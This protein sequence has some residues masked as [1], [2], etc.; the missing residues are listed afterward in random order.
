MYLKELSSIRNIGAMTA[1]F[2]VLLLCF[3]WIGLYNK[4]Q[5][6]RQLV[7]EDAVK[8]TANY[9]RTF[10]E[11]T[12]RTLKG[13]DQI[14]LFL[15]HQAEKDGL[16][17]DLPGF[18]KTGRFAGQPFIALNIINA[19]G[20]LVASSHAAF[21]Q[22]NTSD[23]EFF[24]A[25][26]EADSD[27]PFVG[28]PIAGRE[29][30]QMAIQLTRRINNADGSFAGVAV[31]AVDPRYFAEFYK[32][33]DL[34]EKSSIVL[35]GLDGIVWVRQ[36][37]NELSMGLDYSKGSL[38]EHVRAG[39]T[40]SLRSRNPVDGYERIGSFRVLKEY[41]LAVWVGETE[42]YVFFGLNQRMQGYIW[43][44][45]AMSV[46][47]LLFVLLL[48]YGIQRFKRA[49]AAIRS[50]QIRYKALI[51]Q[52]FEAMVLVDIE[53]QE[54]VGVNRRFTEMLGYSLPE[55]APL[56]A[57]DFVI[58]SQEELNR[59]Y[60]IILR[61]QN[62]LPV[63]SMVFRHKNGA[64]V[65][66]E[67]AG[68]VINIE[69][70]DYLL[71][72]NRDMTQ[73]HRHQQ[74]LAK[75][76]KELQAK[77]KLLE[78]TN[79]LLLKSQRALLHQASH[80]SLT[81]LLNSRAA[82]GLLSKEL[83]RSQR[84]GEGL[85]VGMCDIDCFKRINDTWG[86]QIG[87]EVLNWFAQTLAANVREYDT[88]ARL[89]GDEFLLIL[90]FKAGSDVES[91]FERCCSQIAQGKIKTTEGE[92]IGITTSIGVAFASAD[93]VL[94]QLLAQADAAMYHAK[95]QGRNRVAYFDCGNQTFA[96]K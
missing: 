59:R 86:H 2:G 53:T 44:C 82:M 91:V 28:K 56:Y 55:D 76:L 1:L 75:S 25:H 62:I 40:G 14:A 21:K 49:E 37:G 88:V 89:G 50:S 95:V 20:D 63:E 16:I 93:I 17:M 94:K 81:G 83:T 60:G 68:T 79:A 66:V 41:P 19:N 61:S 6:E 7:L 84:H 31:V 42:E 30:G 65:P 22:I 73:E 74:E 3:I 46:V 29:S 23:R 39:N 8:E 64:E 52:S 27:N 72:S 32:V 57:K 67:R 80:D 71:S 34:G 36:S 15:K 11:H 87:D 85:A 5:D 4:V 96:D 12:V 58:D 26:R 69:G 33:V 54:A 13:L 47:I 78:K 18:V 70:K 90:P 9:A 45:G 10:E 24:R 77:Q 48:L 51:E 43:I 35:L 92:E 38:M